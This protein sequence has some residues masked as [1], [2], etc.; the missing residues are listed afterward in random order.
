MPELTGHIGDNVVLIARSQLGYTESELNFELADDGV[1]QN[2]ITRY[3]QWY[4]NPYGAWSNMFT[5]FCLRYAGLSKV[6]I[7]SGAEAMRMAWEAEGI[8]RHAGGYEPVSGDI[9]FL[10]NNQN[11]TAESTAVVVRYFDF[12]LTIIEGDVDNAVVERE[13]RIDDPTIVGYGITNPRGALMFAASPT[14]AS[15]K[16][17]TTVS[18]SSNLLKNNSTF[19]I[20]TNRNGKYYA[21]DGYGQPVEIQ[22]DNSGNITCSI[23]DPKLLYWEFKTDNNYDNKPAFEIKNSS[24]H[25]Y[26]HPN[27]DDGTYGPLHS[28]NWETAVYTSGNAVKFRGARQDAYL[29]LTDSGFTVSNNLNNG[30]LM[31]FGATPSS[32]SLWLDGTNGNIMD[33][34]GSEDIKYT[35]YSGIPMQLPTTWKSPTKYSYKLAGWVNVKTGEYYS[36]GDEIT[37][38][39][40]TVLYADWVAESYD[41]GV[42][43]SYVVNSISTKDF[44]TTR[45]FDYSSLINLLSTKVSV[46]VSAD[47][48]T[49]TWSHVQGT[50]TV[51]YKG[52]TTLDF[53]FNDHDSSGTLTNPNSLNDRNKYTGGTK[54]Y[55]GILSEELRYVLFSV[56]NLFNPETG[57]GVVGKHYL[58]EGDYLFQ[59]N[60]DPNSKYYGYYYYDADLNAAAY[61]QSEQRFYVYDYLVKASDSTDGDY[62]DFLPLNSA[63]T[64][65][66]G[67][68]VKTYNYNGMTNYSFESR[69]DNNSNSKANLWFG[70]SVDV[71]FY[72]PEVPGGGENSANKDINGN[73]MCFEFTGDDDVWILIDNELVLDLGGIHMAAD[74]QINFATGKVTQNGTTK[75]LPAIPAGDH[76]LTIL[77][78]ERGASM[79]NCSIY[80]NLAP[81]FSLTLQK[82]D[83]L[84][85]KILEGAVFEV[86]YDQTCQN[87]CML[88]E[89][90]QHYV[91][92]QSTNEF[93]ITNGQAYIWGLSP[94]STYYIREKSPPL[95]NSNASSDALKYQSTNGVIKLTLSKKGL[96]SYSATVFE[97]ID[98]NGNPIPISHGFTIYGFRIDE[99]NQ[100][101]YITITNA[102]NWVSTTT[103]VYVEK[104]WGDN[105]DHSGDEVTV[106]LNVTDP[107]GTV[108]RLREVA[109][110][111]ENDWK[112]T[113]VNLPKYTLNPETQAETD[114]LVKYSVSE[115]YVPG[116]THSIQSL[117]DGNT[118]ETPWSESLELV[119]GYTYLLKTSTGTYLSA[120][121]ADQKTFSLLQE[122]ALDKTSPLVLW[123]ATVSDGKTKLTNQS[124]MSINYNSGNSNSTRYFYLAKNS[125]AATQNLTA[126]KVNNG[127]R[128]SYGNYYVGNVNNSKYLSATTSNSA[129]LF[130]P[131][132]VGTVESGYG[133]LITNT[134][135]TTETSVK[136][137]K[138]WNHPDHDTSIYE[139][140]QVTIKLYAN[141]VDT[142][143]TETVSLKT[144]WTATF[145]GLPY[146]DANGNPISYTV[147]EAWDTDDWIPI[148]GEIRVISGKTPTYET[149]ITNSYRW[150]GNFELPS[151]G[152]TGNLIYMLCGLILVSAP[153]VYE[154]S[155]RRKKERRRKG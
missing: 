140:E 46:N 15:I 88:Y 117:G 134:A 104:K 52:Q 112:Y 26:L 142:G 84:S 51:S 34:R 40:N 101:A 97:E 7:N 96:N 154:I 57:E 144:G 133:F 19:I 64:N 93:T 72:L 132:Q 29:Q 4:G 108:R 155:L 10:D 107:D 118:Y 68:I 136:V 99:E 83:V 54:E 75:D 45:V 59:I 100:A 120:T 12:V 13:L 81:R 44:I 43:N 87:P 105:K 78:L 121:G 86:F 125:T 70:M 89:S 77:Y 151:T 9:I 137:T 18:Y 60:N 153:L 126:T 147:V 145:K 23:S 141:N 116:Y 131:I 48:H 42:F 38:T 129:L 103:S 111:A 74:G 113:W 61:N 36:P 58:G 11:G 31:Y 106:Y 69:Y 73:N 47:D 25:A 148:Y 2:G 37:V 27:A 110:C 115:A 66:N 30:S 24:T 50:G 149:T 71:K 91:N 55:A 35:V 109:L 28:V 22:I 124:G 152:G 92:N 76:T 119:N 41:L 82:E 65:N 122:S 20:Y 53:S 90:Y 63:Y 143:R 49:E 56:K 17:G 39:G 85:Q 33:Y 1:T 3:G 67:Q 146:A 14:S 79:S 94:A 98:E 135:L 139:Q 123:T 6:P 16:I 128:L 150:V 62:S 114:Q 95:N 8:Y 32:V 130:T 102:Q 138:Q 21:I 80:F 127:V 5:S